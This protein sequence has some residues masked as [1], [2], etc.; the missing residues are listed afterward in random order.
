MSDARRHDVFER[1]V[2]KA[3]DD[4][5]VEKKRPVGVLVGVFQSKRTRSTKLMIEPDT[6]G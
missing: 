4:E 5:A 1:G 6:V 3:D 2:A